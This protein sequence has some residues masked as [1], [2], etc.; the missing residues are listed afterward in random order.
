MPLPRQG[1]PAEEILAALERFRERD[2]PWRSGRV[3]A[4]VFDG[5][6]DLME[7]GKRAYTMYLT[8]NGL[9]FTAFPSLMQLE[10]A[11]V[12]F[13]REHLRGGPEVVGNF[14][15][16]GTESIMLAVKAARDWARAHRPG[17]E[18]PEIVLPVTAHAAFHKAAHYLGLRVVQVPVDRQRLVAD[19]DAVEQ[20][21]GPNTI[22]LVG[23][24]PCYSF[25]TVDPIAELGE[26]ALRHGLLLHV[27]ACMG[28][29]VLPYFRRLGVEVPDFDFSVPG[30][31]SIS[32]DLHK[33]AYTPKGASLILYRDHELRRHQIF[34]CAR[35]VGYTMVNN[36]VQSSRSGGPMAAAWAV[37]QAA[38]DEGYLRLARTKLE[39]TR[40]ICDGIR[41][42]EG[43]ELCGEPV[44]SLVAFRSRDADPFHLVDEMAAR[45]WYI[46]PSLSYGGLPPHVHLSIAA[47][48]APQVDASLADLREALEA[49]RKLPPPGLPRQLVEPLA[50]AGDAVPD[51]AALRAM[52]QMAGIGGGGL[53]ERMADVNATLDALPAVLREALLTEFVNEAFV[54]PADGS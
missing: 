16:G 18:V 15:S 50:A 51:P 6:P 13:A 23:S 8:E 39:A 40:R 19:A 22:L 10:N 21:I 7:I 29:F 38:G 48:N 9:D 20:A 46:Q 28:G 25:G 24:A 26:L 33:Y 54:P 34:A 45:G 30:V 11:L 52:L 53:P 37:M 35:W 2:L 41:G 4:Y 44:M 27:D 17:V 32:M 43:L 12:G 5:G 1:R 47:S 42:I 14:T 49:A 31:S 3:F 36:A